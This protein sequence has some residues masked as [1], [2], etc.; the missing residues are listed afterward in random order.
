MKLSPFRLHSELFFSMID[1]TVKWLVH[2]DIIKKTGQERNLH[3][4]V[5]NCPYLYR[6][7]TKKKSLNTLFSGAYR[8]SGNS[9]RIV[10][11]HYCEG[12]FVDF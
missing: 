7:F 3:D 1:C 4:L 12:E 6:K 10:K 5:E 11:F 9:W 8:A 2:Q